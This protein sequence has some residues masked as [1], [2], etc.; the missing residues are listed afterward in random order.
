MD[1]KRLDEKAYAERVRKAVADSVRQQVDAG[2]DVVSD[3]EMGKPSLIT[4]A[5][6]RLDG[7]EK[8]E[9]TGRAVANTRD[10]R[11]SRNTT[12]RRWPSRSAPGAAVRARSAPVRSSTRATPSSRPTSTI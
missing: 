8:R 12:S 6:Q 5:A 10:T 3:G 1:G 4:D 2:L 7:L 9:A 11:T